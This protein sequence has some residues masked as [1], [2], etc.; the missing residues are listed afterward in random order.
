VGAQAYSFS[1]LMKERMRKARIAYAASHPLVFRSWLEF[2]FW[3][4][5]FFIAKL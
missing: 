1:P 5:R 2:W 4:I 3:K